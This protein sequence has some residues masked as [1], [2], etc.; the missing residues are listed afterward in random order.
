M[1]TLASKAE[2]IA[3]LAGDASHFD[4]ESATALLNSPAVQKFINSAEWSGYVFNDSA[5]DIGG[6]VKNDADRLFHFACSVSENES[7]N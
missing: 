3:T 7:T 5:P 2:E 1:S 4:A 6:T